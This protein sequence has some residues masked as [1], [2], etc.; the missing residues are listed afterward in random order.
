[1]VGRD[2]AAVMPGLSVLPNIVNDDV[3]IARPGLVGGVSERSRDLKIERYL[4]PRTS[5]D[6]AALPHRHIHME[7]AR[8]ERDVDLP[9]VDHHE[10]GRGKVNSNVVVVVLRN[11]LRPQDP[12]LS[13]L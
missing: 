9:T 12:R 3:R 2:S 4:R 8:R 11:S 13:A 1:M 10:V 7:P 5:T 6:F